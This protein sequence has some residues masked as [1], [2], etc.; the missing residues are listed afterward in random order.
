MQMFFF[1][2]LGRELSLRH[3]DSSP[4][5]LLLQPLLLLAVYSFV[6]TQIFQ[7]RVPPG[8]EGG[9][10]GYLAVAYWPWSAFSE[11]IQRNLTVIKEHAALIRKVAIRRE[12]LVIARGCAIF[13]LHMI[14]YL[15]V[16]VVLSLSG[17]PIEW[18]YLPIALLLI[19][20]LAL[21]AMGLALMLGAIQVIVPS[22][23]NIVQPGLLLI[24][25]STPILWAPSML[26]SRYQA[27]LQ[28]NPFAWWVDAIRGLMLAG[29]WPT[30]TGLL[31]FVLLCVAALLS[32][33]WVFQRLAPH[34]EDF[35]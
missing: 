1:S 21:L 12:L 33:H 18:L 26:P 6:F 27:L 10:V 35:L 34:F 17:Q 31:V 20:L 11:C 3:H 19:V 32:G 2:Q 25:F 14:G 24:F 15:S 5:W 8:L 22:L 29:Q 23:Q 30:L 9:F 4:L 13:L 16:L 28:Y 7:A